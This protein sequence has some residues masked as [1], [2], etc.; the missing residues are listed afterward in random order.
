M[1]KNLYAPF[2]EKP[3]TSYFVVALMAG[4]PVILMLVFI[5][6]P[7]FGGFQ[8][9]RTNKAFN[10][11]TPDSVGWQH[12]EE[13]LGLAL[14]RLPDLP[15]DIPQRT[16]SGWYT[17]DGGETLSFRWRNLDEINL[18]AYEDYGIWERFRIGGTHYAI[19]AKDPLFWTA[20]RNNLVFTSIVVPLNT[21]L[22]LLLAIL[23]NQK[24]AGMNVFRSI[25][26]MPAVTPVA[27]IAVIWLFLYNPEVGLINE[28]IETLSFGAI[29][30]YEWLQDPALAMPA[31]ALMS[32]WRVVGINMLI[33]L[34]GLQNIPEELYEASSIDGASGL[35]QF[36][37]ITL[38]LLRN[39]TI[40]VV[41]TLSV[42]SFR[43][44]DQVQIMTPDGG[45]GDSTATLVWYAVRKAWDE[46]QVG[47]ASAISILFTLVIL[48][49]AIFQ[50]MVARS[51]SALDS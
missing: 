31:I 47:Y 9:S 6:L 45:P 42:A 25:Y 32:V 18:E 24:L 2:K 43:L 21:S 5:I 13:I 51:D 16:S 20:L 10:T 15:E 44:F 33:F 22:A 19:L 29:G 37:L 26:F 27:V 8:L 28:M 7:L 12:Y 1:L 48:A 39:T 41:L 17:E 36:R 49:I 40:F 30:P 38:P 14:V 4:P 34:A 35:Q 50:R 23:V 46:S 11:E 3:N